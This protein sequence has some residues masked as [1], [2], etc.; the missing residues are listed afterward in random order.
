[1]G[2]KDKAFTW[3]T[4]TN[5]AVYGV[6]SFH[7]SGYPVKS[8]D[9]ESLNEAIE[10]WGQFLRHVFLGS[11]LGYVTKENL[12]Q[13]SLE[14]TELYLDVKIQLSQCMGS[15]Q[16]D[17]LAN[18]LEMICNDIRKNSYKFISTTLPMLNENSRNMVELKHQTALIRTESDKSLYVGG[19]TSDLDSSVD[20]QESIALRRKQIMAAINR[21]HRDVIH[22]LAQLKSK[23]TSNLYSDEF[24]L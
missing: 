3:S 4:A 21:Q 20:Y 12:D 7:T 13:L 9:L 18:R 23:I 19:T 2:I 15:V 17:I 10:R 8:D 5:K 22:Q 1:M 6:N 11:S 14:D 24:E 16:D